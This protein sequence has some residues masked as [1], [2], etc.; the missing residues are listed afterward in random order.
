VA[1]DRI[2]RSITSL[3]IR[4]LSVGSSKKESQMSL[5]IDPLSRGLGFALS[6]RSSGRALWSLLLATGL[7]I[8]ALGLTAPRAD[9]MS[10]GFDGGPG[11]VGGAHAWIVMTDQEL[12]RESVKAAAAVACSR[13]IGVPFSGGVCRQAIA[14]MGR[15]V[16][17][18]GRTN[19]G[20]FAEISMW[21]RRT[22][23]GR[24]G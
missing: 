24:W 13:A 4:P 7:T 22:Y 12:L 8:L 20:V 3:D 18:G 1:Q 16:R 23:I 6:D 17:W 2:R 10:Y 15:N 5:K 9:A 14:K 19:R 21:P 11:R